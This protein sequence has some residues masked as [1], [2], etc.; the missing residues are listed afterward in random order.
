MNAEK[1]IDK[2][3]KGEFEV[4]E[5]KELY[6]FMKNDEDTTRKLIL[7]AADRIDNEWVR[8]SNKWT[9]ELVHNATL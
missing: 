4:E 6:E 9:N 2:L 8:K 1:T 5:L 7:D 3:L